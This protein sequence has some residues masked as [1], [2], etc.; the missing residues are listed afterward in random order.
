MKSNVEWLLCQVIEKKQE[1]A[2][3]IGGKPSHDLF[4]LFI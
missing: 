4:H 3:S 1:L 2:N